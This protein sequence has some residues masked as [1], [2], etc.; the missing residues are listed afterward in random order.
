MDLESAAAFWVLQ[1]L[2]N[3]DLPRIAVDAL[4]RGIDSPAL[5]I[6]AGE[7]DPDVGELER[8]FTKVLQAAKIEMPIRSVAMMKAA[9]YYAERIV[10]G[11]LSVSR[12][13]SA[14]CWDL[15]T[16]EDAPERLRVFIGLASEYDDFE[17]RGKDDLEA[18]RILSKIETEIVVEARS[19]LE[20]P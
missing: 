11:D 9:K 1:L 2:P 10:S 13:V 6:L 5:R 4:E 3:A 17:Y 18:A 19:L 16:N 15:C 12:G 20:S 8:L 7:R 14:I